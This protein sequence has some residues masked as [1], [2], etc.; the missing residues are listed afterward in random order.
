MER[1][2]LS[3]I[4]INL[5]KLKDAIDKLIKHDLK[6]CLFLKQKDFSYD[7]KDIVTKWK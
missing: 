3:F 7:R 1:K 4:V 6:M 5:I 2:K